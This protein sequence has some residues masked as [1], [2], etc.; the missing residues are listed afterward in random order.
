MHKEIQKASL[1]C[2]KRTNNSMKK[3]KGNAVVKASSKLV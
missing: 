3:T 1:E 2:S